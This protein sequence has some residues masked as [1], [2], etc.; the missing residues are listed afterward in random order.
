MGDLG[1]RPGAAGERA[2]GGPAQREA[3]GRQRPARPSQ[4]T[5]AAATRTA[6]GRDVSSAREAVPRVRVRG[7]H[8]QKLHPDGP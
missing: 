3:A 2:R 8:A 1:D 7:E 6:G 4:K 5:E